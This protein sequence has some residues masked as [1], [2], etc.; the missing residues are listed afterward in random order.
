MYSIFIIFFYL[1]T[2][3]LLN[4]IWDQFPEYFVYIY[5]LILVAIS[6]WVYKNEEVKPWSTGYIKNYFIQLI[7]WLPLGFIVHWLAK[8]SNVSFPF[9]VTHPK[10]IF[11]LLVL[12]PVL[13]ELIF[14][15]MLW[16]A[17]EKFI[18]K[19]EWQ[20]WISALFFSLGHVVI[21]LILP[22]EFRAFVLYQAA[23]VV[24]LSIGAS[25]LR[26]KTKGMIAPIAVHFLFN[27]G[28]YL[29]RYI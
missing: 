29:A 5:E 24:A 9:D 18:K 8:V 1:T 6:C 2:R 25:Y 22:T 20:I 4:S 10:T 15:Y 17:I 3:V 16:I 21:M 14:R 27:L 7:P 12:A 28:F 11:L 13:E 23:Y 19:T 26:I